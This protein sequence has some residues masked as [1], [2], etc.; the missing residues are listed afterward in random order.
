MKQSLMKVDEALALKLALSVVLHH[1]IC[2]E[3]SKAPVDLGP[4]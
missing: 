2:D 4:F 3:G 1:W